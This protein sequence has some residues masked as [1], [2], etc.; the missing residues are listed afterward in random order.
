MKKVWKLGLVLVGGA[1]L[2]LLAPGGA[3]AQTDYVGSNPPQVA[4]VE[5]TRTDPGT[6]GP[7]VLGVE[8][9]RRVGSASG[10]Q[11]LPVTG[12]DITGLVAL[13]LGAVGVGAAL[14]RRGRA[15]R[16]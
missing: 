9:G 11:G 6:V 1:T 15:Q 5:I 14:V 3:Y 10:D 16:V 2:G 4:G 7:K 13:G 8:A 12:G